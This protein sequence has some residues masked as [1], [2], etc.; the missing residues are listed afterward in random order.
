[1]VHLSKQLHAWGL[2][3][4]PVLQRGCK[5]EKEKEER[6]EEGRCCTSNAPSQQ[7]QRLLRQAVVHISEAAA[8][9]V[10][11]GGECDHPRRQAGPP[12]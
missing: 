11:R 4:S 12:V 7:V 10:E 2:S 9:A 1:M 6:E 5:T 3:A 8:A